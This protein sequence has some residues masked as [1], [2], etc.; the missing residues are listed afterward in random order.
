MAPRA[1]P[2]LTVATARDTVLVYAYRAAPDI[3]L[4]LCSCQTKPPLA[5]TVSGRVLL[6]FSEPD[7][8]ELLLES[9]EQYVDM[10][11]RERKRLR[12]RLQADPRGPL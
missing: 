2:A 1:D 5:S 12:D 7:Q 3:S 6:A 11:Q 4:T 9:D 8:Q 10:N